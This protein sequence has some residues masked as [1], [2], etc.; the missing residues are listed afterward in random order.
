MQEYEILGQKIVITN[1]QEAELASFA[2]QIVNEKI[3]ELKIE[4]PLLG[5]QQLAVLALLHI[6]GNMVKDRQSMDQ[7]RR[8]LDDRCSALML[9]VSHI[10]GQKTSIQQQQSV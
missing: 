8:E 5:P 2:L 3:E 10:I 1:P 6:A 7:Y 4:K 9:E